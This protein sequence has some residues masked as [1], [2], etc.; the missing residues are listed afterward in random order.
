LRGGRRG[1][2][3]PCVLSELGG[4]LFETVEPFRQIRLEPLGFFFQCGA[5]GQGVLQLVPQFVLTD[6][7]EV[8]LVSGPDNF[9]VVRA[10][11]HCVSDE[12]SDTRRHDDAQ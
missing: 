6:E 7:S 5:G 8:S 3:L 10:V 11:R 4:K 12:P 9:L 1:N 2:I